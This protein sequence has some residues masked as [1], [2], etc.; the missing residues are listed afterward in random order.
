M[1][2]KPLTSVLVIL[3]PLFTSALFLGVFSTVS[4]AMAD[5]DDDNS[6]LG[7]TNVKNL[8]DKISGIEIASGIVKFGNVITCAALVP[9]EGTDDDDILYGGIKALVLAKDGD[10]VVYGALGDQIYAG[11]DDDLVVVGGGKYADGGDGDDTIIGGITNTLL[12]GGDGND[13]LFA[14][15][16]TTVMY[17]GKGANNFDCP[18]SVAG[19]ARSVVMDYNPSNGDTLSGPCKI[20]NTIGNSNSDASKFL[21]PDSGETDS[22]SGVSGNTPVP[23]S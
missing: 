7:V 1:I 2:I 9:C 12:V 20:I 11:D 13:K 22:S 18:L 23:V 21:L 14:G 5:D 16:G 4:S 10:D 3:L 6:D 17:G 15:T 19:L 8:N